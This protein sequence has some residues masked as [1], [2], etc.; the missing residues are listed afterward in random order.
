M[1]VANYDEVVA[2]K[3]KINVDLGQVDI[4]VNNAGLLPR[5]SL[6]QGEPRDLERIINVNFIG[7]IWVSKPDHLCFGIF[8][9][10]H[11]SFYLQTIREF[12]P[13]MIARKSGHIVGISSIM[14]YESTC[15]AICYSSTKF[16]IRGLMDGLHEHSRL[17]KLNVKVT[18]VFPPLVNTRK[19]FID[20]FTQF[21]G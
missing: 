19:D 17:D 21:G 6:L 4:L 20:R 2:L 16:A 14:A 1:D 10:N 9:H 15:R 8:N 7:Y 13:D 11:C 5:V 18:T 3:E 12:L